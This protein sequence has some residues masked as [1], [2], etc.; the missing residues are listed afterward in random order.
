MNQFISQCNINGTE[1]NILKPLL[2]SM[3]FFFFPLINH[4]S[5]PDSC[6]PSAGV[7]GLLCEKVS[8][9]SRG[10]SGSAC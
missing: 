8:A 4:T 3:S 6:V 5:M 1:L 9:G 2:S 10:Q 7:C